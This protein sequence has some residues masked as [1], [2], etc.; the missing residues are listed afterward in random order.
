MVVVIVIVHVMVAVAL[1]SPWPCPWCSSWV[2]VT[3][4]V[5]SS[6]SPPHPCK[7][8]DARDP[9]KSAASQCRQW[10][11]G[12]SRNID[13]LRRHATMHT[14]FE[15][16]N[17]D[18]HWHSNFKRNFVINNIEQNAPHRMMEQQQNTFQRKSIVYLNS[19][20]CKGL[21]HLIFLQLLFAL[22]E[23]YCKWSNIKSCKMVITN[24]IEIQIAMKIQ[25]N[26]ANYCKNMERILKYCM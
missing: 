2:V 8:M 20:G 21:A 17:Y 18:I 7:D 14:F 4:T 22:E 3:A 19:S 26:T 24:H 12:A 5:S 15:I 16:N 23:T 6:S 1:S 9:R 10:L 13:I 11:E 25:Q